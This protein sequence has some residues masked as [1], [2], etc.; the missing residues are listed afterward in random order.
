MKRILS[1]ALLCLGLLIPMAQPAQALDDWHWS[2]CKYNV[3]WADDHAGGYNFWHTDYPW[4]FN[5]Y[6]VNHYYSG[7][8][9]LAL[10]WWYMGGECSSIGFPV[11]NQAMH[12]YYHNWYQ[13]FNC[14]WLQTYG[15]RNQYIYVGYHSC[16]HAT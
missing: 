1:I 5:G 2:D 3:M 12:P 15:D 8:S 4:D 13:D 16:I 14:G 7:S 9:T 11:S 6:S 10:H